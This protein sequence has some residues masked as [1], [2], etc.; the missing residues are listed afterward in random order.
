MIAN[1]HYGYVKK[2]G[3]LQFTY[4]GQYN[5]RDDGVVELLTSGTIT[6]LNPGV[7]DIFCVGGGGRGGNPNSLYVGTF[8]GAGGGAG[9]YTA[10]ARKQAVTGSY[11]ITIGDGSTRSDVAGGMTSFGALLSAAGG[12]SG[13]VGAVNSSTS[14]DVL[15]GKDGGSGSGGG[16]TSTSD[17][18]YGLSLIHI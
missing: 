15:T 4:T 17:S 7:I 14:N 2:A 5:Q 9:G 1:T 6:F 18:N 11:N 12:N 3:K 16:V 13:H 8:Y 10:T